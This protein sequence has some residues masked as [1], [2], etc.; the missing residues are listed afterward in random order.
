MRRF[1]RRRT[2]ADFAAEIQAHLELEAARLVEDGISPED[3]RNAAHR[4]FG[5][6]TA[7][8][9]R[10]YETS[11]WMWL[12]QFQQDVRYALRVLVQS[13]AFLATTV[14]T[15]AVGLGLVTIAFTV[16]NAYVLRPF[17]VREP[18]SLYKIGWR[19]HEDG[20]Q[21]FTSRDYAD[22]RER[23]DLFDAV[24]ADDTRFISSNDRTLS[25]SFVSDNYFEALGP[26]LLL[27]RLIDAAD[28]G[29][30]VAVLS[31]QLWARLFASDP[32][33]LGRTV[34][35]DGRPFV[36]LGVVRQEFTGLDDSPRDL[37]A[38]MS[39]YAAHIRPDLSGPN[40]PRHLE[41]TG[42]LRRDV[43]AAQAQAALTPFMTRMVDPTRESG[44]VRA[45]VRP[46]G[47][48]NPLSVE[49]VEVL[50]PIFAAFALVLVTSCANV[51]NVMLARAIAR[52]REIAL[53]LSLGAARGRIVRQLLT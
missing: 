39:S 10:F 4:S 44:E 11:R 48:P 13:P 47:T 37:W 53:R 32:A 27:G 36:I 1:W 45:D 23:R 17:A 33:V 6:V 28:A 40:E 21:S 46:Q 51:S 20:G 15:L 14:L 38:P 34:D 7:A 2:D 41:I 9:E 24:I 12:E 29:A 26:R 3:A 52:E 22:L 30:P 43:T 25:V 50:S 31:Q 18:S 42:R 19:A 35:L 5:N 16:F 8:K 49:L